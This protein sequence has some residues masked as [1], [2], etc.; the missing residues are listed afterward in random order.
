[1]AGPLR[2]AHLLWQARS[3]AIAAAQTTALNYARTL[4]VRLDATFRRTD[5]VLQAMA[6]STPPQA[7][8]PGAEAAFGPRVNGELAALAR[9]F[10]ELIALRIVDAQGEQRYASTPGVM[11]P[12]NYGDREFFKRLRADPAN[13]LV[14]SEVVTGRLSGRPTMVM[15]YP[16]RHAD[17]P[18]AGAVF[19]PMDLSFVQR[20]FQ[21]LDI[22]QQGAVFLRRS[23][24]NGRM[25]LRWPHIEAEVNSPMPATHVIW[26][27]ISAGKSE[28]INAY[29][30]Y[31]DGVERMSGTV[32]VQGYPFFLTVAMSRHE[33]LTGWRRL[34]WATGGIWVAL[35]AAMSVLVWRVQQAERTRLSL[36]QQLLESRRIESLGT[37]AGGIAHDFN[38]ILAAIIG[39]AALARRELEA[40][41]PAVASLEQVSTAAARGR[42]LV[43]QI[44]A[45]GRRQPQALANQ[46]LLPLVEET[47]ALLRPTLPASVQMQVQPGPTPVHAAVDAAR[48]QQVLMNLCTNASHTMR[49][50]SGCIEIGLGELAEPLH[51]LRPGSALAGQPCAHLGVRDEG[52]GMDTATM[53][54]I[55]EPFF[56]TKPSGEGT[57]L[58]LPVV[59][60][61]V[62]AHGGEIAIDSSPGH[63][64]TVHV[65]L[66]LAETPPAAEP[67]GAPPVAPPA[68]AADTR[69]TAPGQRVLYIDDDPV[70]A[71]MVERLLSQAG[72]HAEVQGSGTQALQCL[73]Q[74]PGA[75]DIVITDYNMPGLSGLDVAH[76]L[77]DLCPGTPVY[78]SSGYITEEL[79]SKAQAAGVRGVLQKQNTLEDLLPMLQGRA[80]AMPPARP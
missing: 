53:A 47:A 50:R 18:L 28:T 30:A 67:E 73:R 21:Q 71:L 32:R 6:R 48:L 5:A 20:Q 1:V 25:V 55:F 29:R 16:I 33:V 38:N 76:E 49:G 3:D 69:P 46:P 17:G 36:E 61:I 7:L 42:T 51:P 70:V 57:G 79:L 80:T 35:L 58:G 12:V 39:N 45:I 66:P 15:A 9:A 4:Q 2:I 8:A 54:R 14:F 72:Y 43:Q 74:K 13:A 34:A 75:F 22:G 65:Y 63:G 78:M 62:A 23:D 77:A 44:L 59:Q 64:T 40:P 24:G 11:A 26:Q 19:A 60:G 37:L 56:T 41:H 68:G 31:T 52:A 10:D 27:A